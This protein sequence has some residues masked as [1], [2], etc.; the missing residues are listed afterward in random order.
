MIPALI[1]MLIKLFILHHS[2]RKEFF[3]ISIQLPRVSAEVRPRS[4]MSLR[5]PLK[6]ILGTVDPGYRGEI[7]V[8][9]RNLS[10]RP[11]QITKR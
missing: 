10:N 3:G 6:C 4:G 1:Y 8:D 5:T 2:K 11:N 7:M 9:F